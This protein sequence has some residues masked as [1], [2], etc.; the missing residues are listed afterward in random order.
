MML[1]ED[2]NRSRAAG[3]VCD[4]A[5]LPTDTTAPLTLSEQIDA[6]LL[7][8][9]EHSADRRDPTRPDLRAKAVMTVGEAAMPEVERVCERWSLTL[10]RASR[11]IAV[12]EGPAR[13]VEGFVAITAMYRR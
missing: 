3:V 1:T 2:G 8:W 13:V 5:A 10:E 11:G 9:L 4:M 7:G 12:I 6:M